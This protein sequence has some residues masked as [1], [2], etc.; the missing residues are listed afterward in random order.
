MKNWDTR[1]YALMALLG[2]QAIMAALLLE[3]AGLDYGT[4]Y[5]FLIRTVV[6]GGIAYLG[7][8]LACKQAAARITTQDKCPQRPE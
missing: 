8:H 1:D 6:C 2:T 5:G 4:V 3:A 7:Y